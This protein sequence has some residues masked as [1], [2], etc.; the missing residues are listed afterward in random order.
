MRLDDHSYIGI[1][2]SVDFN[3]QYDRRNHSTDV[4]IKDTRY[5]MG[6]Y[7]FNKDPPFEI[8]AISNHPIVPPHAYQGRKFQLSRIYLDYVVYP[9]G[10]IVRPELDLVHISY[11]Y[12][13]ES[14]FLITLSLSD[15][16]YD[17]NY[18]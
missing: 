3:Q 1:F 13:D 17:M 9:I 10:L 2:H 14:A 11:G 8:T 18:L 15:I 7:I 16:L 12:N 4:I 6:A 5:Y